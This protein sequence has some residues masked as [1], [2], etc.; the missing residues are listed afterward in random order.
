M[1]MQCGDT[2]PC[3]TYIHYVTRLYIQL[4]VY[5]I[6]CAHSL[7]ATNGFPSNRTCLGHLSKLPEP[8]GEPSNA[9]MSDL[10][11]IA[12]FRVIRVRLLCLSLINHSNTIAS[13]RI[14]QSFLHNQSRRDSNFRSIQLKRR[15]G[16]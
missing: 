2:C 7:R 12:Y 5:Y 16:F 15:P 4:V 8:S 13:L 3:G 11:S 1:I 9:Q 6:V 14:P 10:F